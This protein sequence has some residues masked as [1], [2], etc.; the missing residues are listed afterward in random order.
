MRLIKHNIQEMCSSLY[1]VFEILEPRK[2]QIGV[3]IYS[4]YVINQ[5][6]WS[7]YERYF[8]ILQKQQEDDEER[9]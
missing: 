5:L 2:V 8:E 3:G 6:R 9:R 7:N 4:K 1:G